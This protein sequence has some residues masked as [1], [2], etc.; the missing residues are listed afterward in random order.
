MKPRAAL[1]PLEWRMM[2]TRALGKARLPPRPVTVG[3]PYPMT[4]LL[5]TPVVALVLRPTRPLVLE[6]FPKP[7]TT[8]TGETQIGMLNV[9]ALPVYVPLEDRAI[10][11]LERVPLE[12]VYVAVLSRKA[13][14]FVLE[15]AGPQAMPVLEPVVTQVET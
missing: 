10:L 3:L 11:L 14:M 2:A 9:A 12:L 1:D 4:P 8:V 6:M 15:L 5:K 7:K 13:A